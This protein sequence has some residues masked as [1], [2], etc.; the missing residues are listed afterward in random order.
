MKFNV[1]SILCNVFI[2]I[3]TLVV[4]VS[5]MWVVI[6]LLDIVQIYS[7]FSNKWIW[8]RKKVYLL[9]SLCISLCFRLLITINIVY[10]SKEIRHSNW[11]REGD[12]D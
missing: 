9:N 5:V 7:L 10:V 3:Y 8:I 6:M 12:H 2:L 1:K 11:Y 4:I